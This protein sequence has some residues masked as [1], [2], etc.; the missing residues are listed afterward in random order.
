MLRRTVTTLRA[1]N[2]PLQLEH[3]VPRSRGGSDRVS[4]LALA[5][6]PCNVKK[7]TQTAEEFGHPEIQALA[8]MPLKDAAHV[9]SMKTAVV[10][11]LREQYGSNQVSIT[12][13]YET[14]YKRL[15]VLNLPKSH[16]NDAVAIACAI[17]EVVKPLSIVYQCRCIPRGHYQQ[18]NGT[19]SEH[20]VSAPK[21]VQGWKL[22]EL[23]E[24][25]G[26]RG[27]I[28]GRRLKGAFV[29]KDVLTGKTILEVTPRKLRRV[30]RPTQGWIMHREEERASSP[31]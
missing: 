5:C 8:K 3:I 28:G 29:L 12:F 18:F 22:Y 23:V 27:Y 9:S 13:G 10:A 4:N 25:K 17:G 15:Q 31:A 6:E 14:K 26:Y 30:A 21:R 1:T 2:V 16:S 24:A 20:S 7:G 11:R 19:R